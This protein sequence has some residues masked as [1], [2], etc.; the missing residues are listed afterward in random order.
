MGEVGRQIHL[1]P[2]IF[3]GPLKGNDFGAA[4]DVTLDEVATHRRAGG[5][6]SLEIYRTVASELFQIGAVERLFE[7][8]E[9]DLLVATR[10]H[11]QT[12]TIHRQ[13]VADRSLR[14]ELW[15]RQ[16]QLSAAIAHANP[17]HAAYLF[18]QSGEHALTFSAG[19]V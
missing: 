9:R 11:G 8:I 6:R 2:I 14:R 10:A 17:K 12:T 13:A 7:K 1:E 18:D 15:R 19:N 16:L 3:F 5:E 4:I